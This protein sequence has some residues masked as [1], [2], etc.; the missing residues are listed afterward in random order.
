MIM[1]FTAHR[2]FTWTKSADNKPRPHNAGPLID[3]VLTKQ[4]VQTAAMKKGL[5]MKVV[6]RASY[7]TKRA[8]DHRSLQIV[9]HGLCVPT[10]CSFVDASPD[11]IIQCE[12]CGTRIL[13]VQHPGQHPTVNSEALEK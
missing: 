4:C 9:E 11:G 8:D 2:I 1:A 5:H 13:K 10:S 6:A 12:C 7:L 3:T